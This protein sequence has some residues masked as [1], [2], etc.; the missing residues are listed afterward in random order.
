MEVAQPILFVK[1]WTG[2]T[3]EQSLF[4]IW[5]GNHDRLATGSQYWKLMIQEPQHVM[6]D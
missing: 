4:E 3:K 2:G 5:H 1:D 6:I